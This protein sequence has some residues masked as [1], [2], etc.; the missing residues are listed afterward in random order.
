MQGQIADIS[1]IDSSAEMEVDTVETITSPPSSNGDVAKFPLRS[2]LRS[3]LADFNI[4]EG[5]ARIPD[6]FSS[7][8]SD[9]L[10]GYAFHSNTTS[11]RVL[12]ALSEVAAIPGTTFLL[13]KHFRPLLV[14]LFGR[15]MLTDSKATKETGQWERELFILAEV[16]EFVPELWR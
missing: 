6:F 16:V 13:V 8:V 11:G 1:A 9:A 10:L 7:T 12:Q 14:D 5:D 4:I 2:R 15:W 3:F